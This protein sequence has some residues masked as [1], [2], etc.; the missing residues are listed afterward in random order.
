MEL[1]VLFENGRFRL[2]FQEAGSS[3]GGAADGTSRSKCDFDCNNSSRATT[4]CIMVRTRSARHRATA[5]P[6][7]AHMTNNNEANAQDCPRRK[8]LY[9]SCLRMQFSPRLDSALMCW[10]DIGFS[11]QTMGLVQPFQC[12]RDVSGGPRLGSKRN[13]GSCWDACE[14]KED[15]CGKPWLWCF[16][17]V[18]SAQYQV[19]K[20]KRYIG[21]V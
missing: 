9:S 21:V 11:E 20:R 4:S 16:P 19:S 3:R 12:W 10:L 6:G 15:C 8:N 18:G 5:G 14:N 7:N 1:H 13:S 2:F 17:I